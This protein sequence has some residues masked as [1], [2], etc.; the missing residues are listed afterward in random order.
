MFTVADIYKLDGMVPYALNHL[1]LNITPP[2]HGLTSP[3]RALKK[4]EEDRK[5]GKDPADKPALYLIR[6]SGQKSVR[7][8]VQFIQNDEKDDIDRLK[9]ESLLKEIAP[10]EADVVISSLRNESERSKF[11]EGLR[12][13]HELLIV[14]EDPYWAYLNRG[15][16]GRAMERLEQIRNSKGMN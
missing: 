4:I 15:L 8:M 12:S 9:V 7:S 1:Y 14:V 2:S 16:V 13:L 10:K 3:T 11:Q 6:I 5:R